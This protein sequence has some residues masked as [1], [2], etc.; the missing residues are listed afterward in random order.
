MVQFDCVD[1]WYVFQ[2]YS[3][4]GTCPVTESVFTLFAGW[5]VNIASAITVAGLHRAQLISLASIGTFEAANF[6]LPGSISVMVANYKNETL[7]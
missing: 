5:T 6:A 3:T 2:S 1:S 7:R 4:H